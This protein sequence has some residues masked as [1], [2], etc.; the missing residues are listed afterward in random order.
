MSINIY[1]MMW[2]LSED[3]FNIDSGVLID[4][5]TYGV[6]IS[7]NPFFGVIFRDDMGYPIYNKDLCLKGGF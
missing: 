2:S 3:L 1:E 5:E 7:I 6:Y 4:G